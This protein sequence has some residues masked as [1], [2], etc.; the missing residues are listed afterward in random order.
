MFCGCGKVIPAR[1]VVRQNLL[2]L[3]VPCGTIRFFFPLW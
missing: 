3:L 1:M 2:A